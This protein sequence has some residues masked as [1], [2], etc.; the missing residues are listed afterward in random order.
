MNKDL[1]FLQYGIKAQAIESF[2]APVRNMI[3]KFSNK[4]TNSE[5]NHS[6]TVTSD[7]TCS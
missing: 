7:E 6:E 2:T 3:E 5:K 4:N 1:T